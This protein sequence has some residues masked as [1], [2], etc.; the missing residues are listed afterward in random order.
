MSE[1]LWPTWEQIDGW[2]DEAVFV[3]LTIS[4]CSPFSTAINFRSSRSL[5][6]NF[7]TSAK[8]DLVSAN[9]S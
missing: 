1:M 6:S 5:C 3:L 2:D 8:S 4:I 7:E 9:V